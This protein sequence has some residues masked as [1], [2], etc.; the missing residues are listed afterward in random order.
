MPLYKSLVRPDV[1]YCSQVQSP[2]YKKNIKL[3]E[4]VQRRATKLIDRFTTDDAG[5]SNHR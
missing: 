1:E 3:I 4:G 5:M 2:Y